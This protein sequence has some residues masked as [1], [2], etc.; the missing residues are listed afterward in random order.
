MSRNIFGWDLPPGVSTSDLPGNRPEDAAIEAA[1]DEA[2]ELISKA[3]LL[4]VDEEKVDEIA[5]LIVKAMGDA[6]S[7]GYA[8]S[9]ADE[10]EAKYLEETERLAKQY[11]AGEGAMNEERDEVIGSL[12][13]EKASFHPK[14]EPNAW[15]YVDS[16][17]A[18]GRKRLCI[19][20]KD[21]GWL[22]IEEQN[23]DKVQ[24]DLAPFAG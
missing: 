12:P 19:L 10:A 16:I 7:K 21:G 3:G 11:F 1:Y 5:E 24:A 18:D 23:W 17:H 20:P 15:V 2:Y 14:G 6:Y 13:M 4:D 8:A 22:G 9:R